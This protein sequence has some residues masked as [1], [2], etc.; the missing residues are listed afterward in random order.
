MLKF[1]LNRAQMNKTIQSPPQKFHVG[2][3]IYEGDEDKEQA[4]ELKKTKIKIKKR[5]A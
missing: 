2:E 3:V 4:Y 1:E 5:N